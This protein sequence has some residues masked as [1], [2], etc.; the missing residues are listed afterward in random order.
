M[1]E[2]DGKQYTLEQIQTL[3]NEENYKGGID[4]FI[5]EKGYTKVSSGE[6]VN[7]GTEDNK[8]FCTILRCLL[9]N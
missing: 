1:Y 8:N 2:L 9:K 7:T 3:L 5:A 4:D 6:F